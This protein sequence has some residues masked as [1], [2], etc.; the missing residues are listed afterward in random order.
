MQAVLPGKV[1]D[2]QERRRARADAEATQELA[3]GNRTKTALLAAVSHDLRTPLAAI[4]AASSSLRNTAI[5][6]SPEDREELLAGGVGSLVASTFTARGE[7]FGSVSLVSDGRGAWPGQL[8]DD[9]RLLNAAITSRLTL[10]RS[11]R[12][13]AEAIEAAYGLSEVERRLVR[14]TA[15]PRTPLYA[16]DG[17]M[18]S[19]TARRS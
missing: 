8:I 19:W 9:F 7:M 18:L 2:R 16:P 3:E 1:R 4:K 15:P 6:W 5:A 11:R 14:Q 17:G 13:L 10:E 12:A